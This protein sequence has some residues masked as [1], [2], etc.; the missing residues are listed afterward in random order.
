M[1]QNKNSR[2]ERDRG[3]DLGGAENYAA[4]TNKEAAEKSDEK[5][6]GN[7]AKEEINE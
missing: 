3:R 1:M 7:P 4:A 6:P 5:V 2:D